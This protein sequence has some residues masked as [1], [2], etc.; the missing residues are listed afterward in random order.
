[1][2]A[3]GLSDVMWVRIAACWGMQPV[4]RVAFAKSWVLVLKFAAIHTDN[5][6]AGRGEHSGFCGC[7]H[8]LMT[9]IALCD[10]GGFILTRI[11]V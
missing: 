5:F 1:M 9:V 8:E 11:A 2:R 10:T 6:P 7:S 3:E 4:N